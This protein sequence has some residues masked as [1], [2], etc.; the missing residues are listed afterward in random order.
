MTQALNSSLLYQM[1][2]VCHRIAQRGMVSATDGNVSV[3]TDRG[4][5]YATRSSVHKGEV[6]INDIVE[7]D[8]TGQVMSGSGKP[9][10][11]LKMHLF[12]YEQRPDVHAVVHAHPIFAT[13]FAASGF[14]L[15]RPVFPEVVLMLG[16][17]P[18]ADYATPST[19]EVP[20][21]IRPFVNEHNAILLA[22]HGAVTYGESLKAAYYAME[23]L[24]HT[25]QI[26]FLARMLGGER[27]LTPD[28]IRS[29]LAVSEQS[30]GKPVRYLSMQ[31]D[32]NAGPRFSERDVHEI[33]RRVI[34]RLN[35]KY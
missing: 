17:I 23:K 25:A 11:E 27:P 28:Q 34:E 2:D 26:T 15:D 24:E 31:E 12:I 21:S 5:F 18:L 14:A 16:K 9:S 7:V 20:E 33:V 6:T 10:T 4:T 30:Y 13:A 19:D 35:I 1:V 32:I 29:L 8:R 22:N 3:R